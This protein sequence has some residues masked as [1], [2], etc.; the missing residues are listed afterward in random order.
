MP[1]GHR[2]APKGAITQP[3]DVQR[4]LIDRRQRCGQRL[5]P[6]S[7]LRRHRP[8]EIDEFAREKSTI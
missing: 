2:S 7:M 1:F 5:D 3:G 6:K 8:R 4:A